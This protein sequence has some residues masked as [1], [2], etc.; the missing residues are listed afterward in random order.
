MLLATAMPMDLREFAPAPGAKTSGMT[1]RMKAT[2]SS[3]SAG[4]GFWPPAH[5]GFKDGFAGL[6]FEKF[7]PVRGY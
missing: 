6:A 1:P 3:R 5:R 4:T 7:S 2:R